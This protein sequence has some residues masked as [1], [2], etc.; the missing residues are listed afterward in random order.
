MK[1]LRLVTITVFALLLLSSCGSN[2]AQPENADNTPSKPHTPTGE[3]I[4]KRT[5]ITCHQANGAGIP[6]TYP[7]LAK[8]D[9][10]HDKE[11]T[12]GQVIKGSSGDIVVNGAKFSNVMP[13]QQLNDD[14]VAAVLTYVYTNLGNTGSPVT[15]DEVK[16]VRA[17]L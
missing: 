8:S 14:E 3:D 4:Y 16:A 9:Y 11:K 13:P 15:A 12:I 17:K 6:A 2:P 10:I 7:P 1:K 5:C